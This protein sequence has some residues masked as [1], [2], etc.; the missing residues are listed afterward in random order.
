MNNKYTKGG[1][2]IMGTELIYPEKPPADLPKPE[3]KKGK[4]RPGINTGLWFIHDPAISY[5]HRQRK[6]FHG[7]E[8]MIYGLQ[9]L[10]R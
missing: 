6:Q 9:I 7:R 3:V 5:L 8:V 10:L 1:V 4:D 2:L